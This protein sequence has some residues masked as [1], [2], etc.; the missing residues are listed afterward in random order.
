[1]GWNGRDLRDRR[2]GGRSVAIGKLNNLKAKN[3]KPGRH[4]DGGGLWLQVRDAEHKSWLFRFTR[5][6]KARQ[7]GL[8]PFPDVTLVA[9]REAA[10]KISRHAP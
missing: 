10:Q 9:A 1:V 5:H 6:G 7:M 4:G 8:G 2:F 3:A